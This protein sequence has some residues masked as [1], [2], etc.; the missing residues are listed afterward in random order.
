[1]KKLL[2]SLS[3]ITLLLAANATQAKAQTNW[4]NTLVDA[5]LNFKAKD[6]PQYFVN[7][8]PL[9][10]CYV[11][12]KVD[13]IISDPKKPKPYMTAIGFDVPRQKVIIVIEVES[14]T[15]MVAQSRNGSTISAIKGKLSENFLLKDTTYSQ[16]LDKDTPHILI[17]ATSTTNIIPSILGLFSDMEIL[18]GSKLVNIQVQV[19][20]L[21]MLK[22]RKIHP[23]IKRSDIKIID[24]DLA[25]K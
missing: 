9:D 5:T 24:E 21:K 22:F 1:M 23:A 4:D 25:N 15:G 17:V 2:F 7:P 13:S 12:F 14:N 11:F 16:Y 8:I 20:G 19:H 3:L 6:I 18:F 10:K